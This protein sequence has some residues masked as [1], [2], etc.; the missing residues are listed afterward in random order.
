VKFMHLRSLNSAC[1]QSLSNMPGDGVVSR[2]IRQVPLRHTA[3]E[4]IVYALSGHREYALLR[5]EE[6]LDGALIGSVGAVGCIAFEAGPVKGGDSTLSYRSA[7]GVIH[8]RPFRTYS[9]THCRSKAVPG[10]YRM[11]K[12]SP[13]WPGDGAQEG[14]TARLQ[15]KD[16]STT[17]NSSSGM[18]RRPAVVLSWY[19]PE[20][21]RAAI[22]G[23]L[24]RPNLPP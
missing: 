10:W 4:G 16:W 14:A 2:N 20:D 24:P 21:R 11:R 8:K 6:L 1:L 23:G 12:C 5:E 15:A 19:C 22:G 17:L 3:A 18:L 9:H 13:A 7:G